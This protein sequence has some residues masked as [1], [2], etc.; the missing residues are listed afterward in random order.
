MGQ[1]EYVDLIQQV[2]MYKKF[3]ATEADVVLICALEE[4]KVSVM[5]MERVPNN[6]A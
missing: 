4:E 6:F 5:V 3:N 1:H 2:L